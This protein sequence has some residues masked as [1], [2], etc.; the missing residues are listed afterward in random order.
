M[1]FRDARKGASAAFYYY[2][3]IKGNKKRRRSI[4]GNKICVRA[5]LSFSK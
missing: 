2:F 1:L 5:P 3:A 4:I